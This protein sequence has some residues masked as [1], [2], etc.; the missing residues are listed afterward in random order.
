MGFSTPFPLLVHIWT[1]TILLNSSTLPRMCT[2]GPTT[3][4]PL[5][6][7]VLY[8]K[9]QRQGGASSMCSYGGASC[10]VK[11]Y[12]DGQHLSRKSKSKLHCTKIARMCGCS[13]LCANCSGCACYCYKRCYRCDS[14]FARPRMS[15]CQLPTHLGRAESHRP[16]S[17][18]LISFLP[19]RANPGSQE[20]TATAS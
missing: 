6:A 11:K 17:P 13:Q 5:K 2:F 15:Q 3:A 14:C 12:L 1:R 9:P 7:N 10:F 8:W 20:K 19:L 4:L 16:P 18:Q